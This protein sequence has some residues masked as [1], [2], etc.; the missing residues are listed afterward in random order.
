MLFQTT[1]QL[2]DIIDPNS[3]TGADVGKAIGVVVLSIILAYLIRKLLT[4]YLA[5]LDQLSDPITSMVTRFAG[6]LIITTGILLA[7]PLLGFQLQPA[8]ILVL[9]VGVLLFFAARPLMEDF[10]AG[11]VLQTRS[12]FVVGDLIDHEGHRGTVLEIDGRATVILTPEGVTVRIPNT[13]ILAEPIVNLSVYLHR[14]S[15]VSVGVAYGTDLD[16]A[17]RVLGEAV[18]GLTHVLED[19]PPRILAKNYGD[20]SINFDI[21][22][23]H[24]PTM[25]DEAAA[26]DEAMK[27]VNSALAAEGITIPFPQRDIWYRNSV[28]LPERGDDAT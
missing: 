24:K 16:D 7:M 20:S 8:M 26:I 18:T 10:S 1:A 15:T 9:I 6:Y 27:S 14:R 23:W 28:P 5:K 19:P 22:I 17:S 12:P 3:V 4:K 11:L 13:T 2:D 21:W 25:L